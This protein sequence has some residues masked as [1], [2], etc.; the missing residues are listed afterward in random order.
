MGNFQISAISSQLQLLVFISLPFREGC[1]LS[2]ILS[3]K[4]VEKCG[5]LMVTVF[6]PGQNV[7]CL[8]LSPSS[9]RNFVFLRSNSKVWRKDTQDDSCKGEVYLS[10]AMFHSYGR[11]DGK[12]PFYVSEVFR[13]GQTSFSLR[14]K[15]WSAAVSCPPPLFLTS[16]VP[17]HFQRHSHTLEPMVW[18]E[19]VILVNINHQIR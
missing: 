15:S 19:R 17:C 11:V 16:M 9:W 6:L 14:Q 10:S 12:D 4:F 13:G 18:M 5:D 7:L 1:N 2:A 8:L 3:S